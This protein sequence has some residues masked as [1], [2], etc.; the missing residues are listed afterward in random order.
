MHLATLKETAWTR[1]A[2]PRHAV[3]MDTTAVRALEKGFYVRPSL[4]NAR[5]TKHAQML[6]ATGCAVLVLKHAVDAPRLSMTA[7]SLCVSDVNAILQT[8]RRAAMVLHV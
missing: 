8:P 6:L 5:H 3:G 2:L 7:P 1:S 4:E